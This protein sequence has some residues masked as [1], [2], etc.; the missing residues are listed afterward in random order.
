MWLTNAC[1]IVRFWSFSAELSLNEKVVFC[2]ANYITDQSIGEMQ[3]IWESKIRQRAWMFRVQTATSKY[4]HA[5]DGPSRKSIRTIKSMMF[6][7]PCIFSN[8][9]VE[10]KN[11]HRTNHEQWATVLF[12]AVIWFAYTLHDRFVY[13]FAHKC[14][15]EWKR[16]SCP[17]YMNR[18]NNR[19]SIIFPF[20]LLRDIRRYY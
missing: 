14:Q 8:R 6:F 2:S 17:R 16:W 18:T 10:Q 5:Y 12:A 9:F 20:W 19:K 4:A 1:V 13:A 11:W 7:L 3:C 15:L